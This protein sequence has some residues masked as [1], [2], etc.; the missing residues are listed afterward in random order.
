ME[1][2]RVALSI[3]RI[4]DFIAAHEIADQWQIFAMRGLIRVRERLYAGAWTGPALTCAN[5]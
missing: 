2:E 4:D 5:T 3:Q 1:G